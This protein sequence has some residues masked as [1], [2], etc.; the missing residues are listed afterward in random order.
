MQQCRLGPVTGDSLPVPAQQSVGGDQPAGASG[1]GERGCDGS[2]QASVVVVEL[3]S[4]ALALQDSELVAEH[5]DLEV[6]GAFRAYGQACQ[7]RQ[8][9]VED[10]KHENK[11]AACRPWSAP[12]TEFRAPTPRKSEEPQ[13]SGT[14][15]QLSVYTIHTDTPR[16]PFNVSA[17]PPTISNPPAA[18]LGSEITVALPTWA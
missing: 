17:G 8:E 14:H 15:N 9:P 13:I 7:R 10:T 3:G 1:A 18:Q 5:E 12:P 6:L 4:G 2:E 11:D 16:L